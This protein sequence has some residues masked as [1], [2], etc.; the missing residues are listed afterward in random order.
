MNSACE[1]LVKHWRTVAVITGVI[2]FTL[3]VYA[4]RTVMFPFLVGLL[5]AYITLPMISWVQARLPTRYWLNAKRFFAIAIVYALIVL[6][7]GVLIFFVFS[8]IINAL[9]ALTQNSSEY[10]SAAFSTLNQWTE[11]LRQIV[12][13]EMRAMI[14]SYIQ[15]A[16][17]TLLNSVY[18][19]I[20]NGM[21]ALPSTL[22]SILG[23]V[24]VPFF[25]FYILKDR[26][27]LSGL[28]SSLPDWT[29]PH[30][31]NILLIVEEA[32]GG[33]IRASLV[34]GLVVGTLTLIGLMLI[35]VP[36]APV[37]AILAGLTEM[38][39]IIGPWIGGI[40]A[41]LVTLG[42]APDKVIWVVALFLSVQLLENMLLVPR[43]R[44]AY[45]RIHPA[46]TIVLLV[47]GVQFAGIWGLILALPLTATV[48]GVYKYCYQMAC[49][50]PKPA[51][52]SAGTEDNEMQGH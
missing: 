33:Y 14:D 28:F 41:V 8:A 38:V 43:I 47:V 40:V 17:E 10:F 45:S 30:A 35:R 29:R 12:P 22:S 11:S 18:D 9:Y 19:G 7:L 32:F 5:L 15:R 2:V 20:M 21:K 31:R 36:F 50:E 39:P 4:L 13:P 42:L 3:I 6:A 23:L 44:S 46:I 26:E 25:L 16:G 49:D 24:S 52:K 37:L 51:V 27:K 48:V 34:L 1:F